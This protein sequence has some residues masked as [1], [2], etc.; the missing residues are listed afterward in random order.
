MITPYGEIPDRLAVDMSLA[1]QHEWLAG[2]VARRTVIKGLV[3]GTAGLVVPGLWTQT[4]RADGST[5]VHGRH[6]AYGV[7][8]RAEMVVGF[9]V[10]SPF[11]RARVRATSG[12]GSSAGNEPLGSADVQVQM[13]QGSAARYC[14]ARLTGLEPD[15]QYG[16][17]VEL[18]GQVRSRGSFRTAP[19]RPIAFRFTA[20]GD[21]GTGDVPTQ[22][23]PR[24]DQLNPRLHL[25][26]GDLCYADPTGTGGP[27]DSFI[28]ARWDRWLDQN[29]GVAGRLPWMCVPGNHE[30]EP[31]YPTHGYAGFLGRVSPGGRSPIDIPVATSFQVGSVGF[32]GLDSNDVSYELSANRGWTQGAQ[33]RW[34]ERTLAELRTE[35]SGVDFV[36]AFLHHSPYS[37]SN[38]HASE[39]GVREAWVPLFD[40]FGVDLV[41]SGHNHC[42]ERTLPLRAGRVTSAD[43]VAVDSSKGTTYVTAGGGGASIGRE[44]VFI[45]FPNKTRVYGSSGY[46]VE[47]ESWSIGNKTSSHAVLCV[48]VT[49]SAPGQQPGMTVRAIDAGGTEVDRVELSRPPPASAPAGDW[50]PGP[51]VIGGSVAAALAVGGGA[52]VMGARRHQP[53]EADLVEPPAAAAG[54]TPP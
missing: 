29:D 3:A 41:I 5:V 35:G 24:V 23:L 13:V 36:V 28:P 30:M 53:S 32:V 52:A 2:R 51:W 43:T 22:V 33:T 14:H 39:G 7:D 46:E 40:R 54:E 17:E 47:T 11:A 37:T 9:A 12:S 26:C 27:G 10:D 25:M 1:E 50:G 19:N 42:Y 38:T 21:Q 18:D 8:P 16:Y 6:L 15:T 48:D 49:P 20:F 34:L 31:G 4:A 44:P 45:P